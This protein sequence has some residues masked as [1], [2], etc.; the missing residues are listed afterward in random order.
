MSGLHG[1]VDI[2]GE[3]VATRAGYRH[4]AANRRQALAHAAQ[5]IAGAY[6]IGAATIVARAQMQAA[7]IAPHAQL[8]FTG[9]G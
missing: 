1:Q 4:C 9:I 2:E 6:R 5:A 8:Q 3:T 7:R